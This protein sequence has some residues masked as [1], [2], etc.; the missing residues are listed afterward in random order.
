MQMIVGA[1][2]SWG[3]ETTDMAGR[4]R[5]DM[6]ADERPEGVGRFRLTVADGKRQS[7]HDVFLAPVR[8]RANLADA[9]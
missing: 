7:A 1:L 9:A 3:A 2:A 4:A 6:F 8:R 5:N